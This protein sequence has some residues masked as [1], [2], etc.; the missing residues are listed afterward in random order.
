VIE[1]R[2]LDPDSNEHG[3]TPSCSARRWE[4]RSTTS[5]PSGKRRLAASVVNLKFHDLRREFGSRLLEAIGGNPVIVRDWLGH[6]DFATPIA[7]SQPTPSHYAEPQSNSS[8]HARAVSHRIRTNPPIS[9]S[10]P[11]TRLALKSPEKSVS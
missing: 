6:A 9:R 5:K 3:P 11:I 8:R 4:N 10:R 2:R 7:T 1:M